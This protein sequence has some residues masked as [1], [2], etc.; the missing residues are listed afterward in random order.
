VNGAL[1]LTPARAWLLLVA[2]A[3]LSWALA[4]RSGAARLATTAVIVIAAI[5]VRLV[6]A[7]F[8]ELEPSHLPWRRVVDV[9]VVAVTAIILGG[10]W[11]S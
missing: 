4:E 3:M 10:Y 1:S 5:K 8:M 2:L 6:V 11:F 9:W 7:H